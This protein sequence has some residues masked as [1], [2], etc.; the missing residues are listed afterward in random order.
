MHWF[1]QRLLHLVLLHCH[2][3]VVMGPFYENCPQMA[4]PCFLEGTGGFPRPGHFHSGQVKVELAGQVS[5]WPVW[6]YYY[7]L[8]LCVWRSQTGFT[9]EQFGSGRWNK[10]CCSL[11]EVSIC[12]SEVGTEKLYLTITQQNEFCLEPQ[13]AES[14]LERQHTQSAHL[15]ICVVWRSK[16]K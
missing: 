15:V 2:Y 7:Q 10:S 12:P 16:W 3:H 6:N 14:P 13:Q 1:Q 11:M 8:S 5:H 9:R 4:W